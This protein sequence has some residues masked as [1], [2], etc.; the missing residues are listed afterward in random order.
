MRSSPIDYSQTKQAVIKSK[1]KGHAMAEGPTTPQALVVFLLL[2]LT[3]GHW[4]PWLVEVSRKD[5]PSQVHNLK[6]PQGH[7]VCDCSC[8]PEHGR[9]YGSGMGAWA[10]N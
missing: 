9:G 3:L 7:E 10:T 1:K 8:S 2:Y 5:L 4:M 6:A